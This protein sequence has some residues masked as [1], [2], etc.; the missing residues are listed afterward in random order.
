V[1]ESVDSLLE[2][3][4]MLYSQGRFAEAREAIATRQMNDPNWEPPVDLLDRLTLAEARERLVNASNLDQYETVIRI[5]SSNPGLL[6][7]SE[8]DVLWRVAESFAMTERQGRARDAYRYVLTNCDNAPERLATMQNAAQL[9][10]AEMRDELLAL[11]RFD[12]AGAGEFAPVRDTIARDALAAAG[13]D[14]T[15]VV[16]A[17]TLARVERLA[18]Q[19][20]GA[21]DARLLG[22]YYLGQDNAQTAEE[23]FRMA[24]EREAEGDAAEGLA[25]ALIALDRFADAEDIVYPY[26][27]ENDERRGVYLAAAANL[28]AI[29]P[30]VVLS[31][32]VLTRI[33]GEVAE[34]RNA[35]AA[36][37]LGW[38]A[39]AYGQH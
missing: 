25:L 7:C 11:E 12:N 33:V 15:I 21:S 31:G 18:R 34:A 3:I 16:D 22:W 17:E 5:G 29:E 35:P 23:W 2:A 36:Q 38:Y 28:L 8:V 30:R 27:D 13:E 20:D 32:E 1:P 9:L 19:G 10:S 37:Q 14:D 6:T 24:F 26:R 39:R 4:W